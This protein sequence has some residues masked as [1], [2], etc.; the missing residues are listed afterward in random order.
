MIGE[1]GN[2]KDRRDREGGFHESSVQRHAAGFDRPAAG[3]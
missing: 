3:Q 2:K 1:V